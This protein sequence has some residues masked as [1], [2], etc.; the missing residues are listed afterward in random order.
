MKYGLRLLDLIDVDTLQRIQDAFSDMTGVAAL[1]TDENGMAVTQGSNF[2]EFCMKYTRTSKLGCTRC[3][4][5]DQFGATMALEEGK[6]VVYYCHAGLMDFAAP[7]MVKDEL[8]G[9][10]I[11]GQVLTKPPVP[12]KNENYALDIGVDPQE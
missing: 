6:S 7:I 8:V 12:Q 11:G 3:E 2:S 10:F 5:C 4:Q 1:T 9:C